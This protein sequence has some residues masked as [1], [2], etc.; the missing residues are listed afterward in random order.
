M[1]RG[2]EAGWI[3]RKGFDWMDKEKNRQDGKKEKF[4]TGWIRRRR[5]QDG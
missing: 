1:R 4:L 2:E 5:G 3:E